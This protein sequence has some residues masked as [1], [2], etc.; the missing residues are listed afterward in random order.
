MLAGVK[1]TENIRYLWQN[2]GLFELGFYGTGKIA[3]RTFMDKM[4]QYFQKHGAYG[5]S[6]RCPGSGR[7]CSVREVY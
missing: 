6:A 5:E 7:V 3:F 4:N 1:H 2:G